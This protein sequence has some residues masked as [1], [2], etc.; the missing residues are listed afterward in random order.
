[1]KTL[2]FSTV[3]DLYEALREHDL[4]NLDNETYMFLYNDAG[5]YAYYSLEPETM[6]ELAH[7]AY[8]EESP[9]DSEYLGAYLGP[10]GYIVDV[11]GYDDDSWEDMEYD[12]Y[13]KPVLNS[14]SGDLGDRFIYADAESILEYFGEL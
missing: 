4:Y 2:T 5:A 13:I 14:L 7:E 3:E 11:E 12:E 1:M 9:E 10:G 6:V 8:I